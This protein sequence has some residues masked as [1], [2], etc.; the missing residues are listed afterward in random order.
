M[1]NALAQKPYRPDPEIVASQNDA[2]RRF[3]C[4]GERP[5]EVMTGQLVLTNALVARGGPFM[6]L[7]QKMVGEYG[8]F[9]PDNDPEG[10][11]D[12][13]AIDIGGEKIFWKIDLFEAG[14]NKRW[15]AER[16]DDL[17]MTDRVLTIMLASDW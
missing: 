11:H 10:Y 14:S 9:E 1:T 5:S 13:G 3:A 6:Q 17:T 2:F 8:T 7:A 15:G 4:L 12:F 16:P